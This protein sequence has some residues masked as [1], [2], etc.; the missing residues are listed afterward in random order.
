VKQRPLKLRGVEVL[1]M[2]TRLR[3]Q[4]AILVLRIQVGS[5]LFHP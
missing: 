3:G 5:A 1:E 4:G 2:L